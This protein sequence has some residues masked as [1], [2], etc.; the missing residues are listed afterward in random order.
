[1]MY[2]SKPDKSGSNDCTI[3]IMTTPG[4]KNYISTHLLANGLKALPVH[5]DKFNSTLVVSL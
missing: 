5:G 4:S 3:R 2:S 1:M